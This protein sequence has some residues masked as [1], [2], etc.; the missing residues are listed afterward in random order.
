M[1]GKRTN[2]IGGVWIALALAACAQ[3]DPLPVPLEVSAEIGQGETRAGDTHATD[4]DKRTFVTGDRIKISKSGGA[5]ESALYQ[6]KAESSWGL[7]EG[8]T[9]LTTTGSESFA[10]SFPEE[11][12]GILA[13]QSTPTNFWK[14]NRLTAAGVL[15][16]NKCSFTFAPAAAKVTVV[17]TYQ[18]SQTPES[19]S[20]SGTGIRT[21]TGASETIT[22]YCASGS[23]TA[24]VRHTY[25]AIVC[26]GS[27]QFIIR[28]KTTTEAQKTYT[29]TSPFTLQAGYNYQYNFTATNE[30][31]LTG[32]TVAPFSDVA[33]ENVG[34][35]T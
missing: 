28:L 6:R 35:A 31:I 19:A 24:S 10:A 2:W 12:S 11:F 16:G 18:S 5:A 20:L 15:N 3:G 4:Y 30:L 33:E 14:S 26:P 21:D 9:A 7:A 22:P 8:Q 32:V 17:V 1:N 25:V 34:S 29:D 27:R 23:T 13:D